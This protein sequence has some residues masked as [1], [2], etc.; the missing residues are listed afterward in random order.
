MRKLYFSGLLM[1]SFLLSIHSCGSAQ[2]AVEKEKQA[3]LVRDAV[4]EGDFVFNANYAYPTGYK[5]L[6]LSPFYD[7]KVSSDTVKTYLPFYGRAYRA[8][9]D[10]SEGGYRFTS[11]DF[12]YRVSK[13]KK[14]GN[15]N[16]TIVFNDQQRPLTFN[17]DI[18]ENGT[19]RLNVNDANRQAISF[20]GDLSFDLL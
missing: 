19:A 5:S 11:T 17:F 20:Q 1:L 14:N 3:A 7:V 18:W 15:W 10:P 6:Y 9:L 13:G 12:E 8:S 4:E 2:S 16:V